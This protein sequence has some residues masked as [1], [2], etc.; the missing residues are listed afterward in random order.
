MKA[1]RTLR[2]LGEGGRNGF[3]ELR[4]DTSELC[5]EELHFISARNLNLAQVA[6]LLCRADLY[7]GNDSGITHLAAAVGAPTVALFG[8]SDPRRWAPRGPTVRLLSLDVACSPCDLDVMKSCPHRKC[9]TEFLPE[10]V[11]GALEHRAEITTLT[12]G[13]AGIRVQCGIQPDQTKENAG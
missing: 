13:G 10:K 4:K 2:S 9:L 5:S 3:E 8:P 7:L 12:W 11:I 6:A 1:R